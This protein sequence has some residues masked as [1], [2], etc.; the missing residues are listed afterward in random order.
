VSAFQPAPGADDAR[1]DEDHA[2]EDDEMSGVLAHRESDNRGGAGRADEIVLDEIEQEP[3]G[4]HRDPE[5][6][7]VR[8]T[9]PRRRA[10][11]GRQIDQWA[12]L[13]LYC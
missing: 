11:G 4:H 5:P 8:K 12:D 9:R 7:Q 6:R 13:L 10:P 3:E 2:D 1:Q